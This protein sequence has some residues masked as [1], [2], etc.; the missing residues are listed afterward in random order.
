MFHNPIKIF[1]II[2]LFFSVT[3]MM[4]ALLFDEVGEFLRKKSNI[5]SLIVSF[6]VV[7]LLGID[8]ILF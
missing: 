8:V 4:Y 3:N 1:G 7:I 2:V 6:I 5:V